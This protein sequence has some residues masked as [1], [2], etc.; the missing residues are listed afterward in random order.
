MF[1]LDRSKEILPNLM[2]LFHFT[3]E[4]TETTPTG[5]PHLLLN[6]GMGFFLLGITLAR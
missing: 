5:R 4:E 3:D 6:Y 1:K 2:K